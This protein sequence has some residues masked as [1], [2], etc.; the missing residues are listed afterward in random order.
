M[1]APDDPYHAHVYYDARSR[2][3]AV[4]LREE[5]LA[6]RASGSWPLAFVG[7]LRDAPLGPHPLPQFELH[8][9]QAL[10]AVV[11]P[12]LA[13]AGLTVLVHPLTLDDLADHTRDADWIGTPLPLDLSV[14]DPPG[15]N[16]GLARFGVS[17]L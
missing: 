6:A 16:Q 14:L 15:I 4:R 17:D 8:F 1:A 13:N 9:R 5:L 7:E 2:D 12:R 3:L 11:R 10:L